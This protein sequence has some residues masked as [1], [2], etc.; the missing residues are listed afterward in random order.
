M[1]PG[2]IPLNLLP[3][4]DDDDVA[5]ALP[6]FKISCATILKRGPG[7]L[8]GVTD[9]G[10]V[11]DWQRLCAEAKSVGA[12]DARAFFEYNFIA[13]PSLPQGGQSGLFTGYY[14]PLLFGSRRPGGSFRY[15]LHQR[16]RD[17]SELSP[18]SGS[19]RPR[20][21]RMTRN[22]F[23]PYYSRAQ[24]ASGVLDRHGAELVWVDDPIEK[25]FLEIQGSGQVQLDSGSRIRVGYAAQNGHGYHPIG[26]DLIDWGEVARED[27]SLQAIRDWLRRAS[28][29]DAQRLM[30]RNPSYVF[31]RELGP[32]ETTPGP[33]GAMGLPLTPERSV[34]VDRREIPLGAP[35]WIDTTVPLPEGERPL[36]RLAVAQDVG[37]AIKGPARADVFWGAGARAEFAAGHMKQPGRIWMLVPRP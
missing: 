1:P 34:A 19:S 23:Q 16:P 32:V 15:P 35:V 6:A 25:F 8:G 13:A 21:G 4:W 22:G 36:R 31:F 12:A 2:R 9:A 3:G 33:I 5:S 29:E 7:T 30:N 26:R 37:G 28:P 14:E 18:A 24:I 17:L 10:N 11:A 20:F 27:M